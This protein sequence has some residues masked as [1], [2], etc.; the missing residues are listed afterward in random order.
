MSALLLP[1]AQPTCSSWFCFN[2]NHEYGSYEAKHLSL[3]IHYKST[4]L[5]FLRIVRVPA[6]GI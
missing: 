1:A 4:S 6:F 2:E 5:D 3:S